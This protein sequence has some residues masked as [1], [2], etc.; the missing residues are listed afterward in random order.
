MTVTLTAAESFTPE[1]YF[2]AARGLASQ[3]RIANDV[4]DG[5]NSIQSL[6][7]EDWRGEAATAFAVRT[8]SVSGSV[9]ELAISLDRHADLL[10]WYASAK[11]AVCER[12]VAAA[13]R[14]KAAGFEVSDDWRLSLSDKQKRGTGRGFLI[15]QMAS[16]QIALNAFAHAITLVDVQATAQL[17]NGGAA[18][19]MSPHDAAYATSN[20]YTTGDSPDRTIN[21]DDDF[22]FGSKRGEATPEDLKLWLKWEAMLR[23]AQMLRPDLDDALPMYEHFRDAS[24]T[25]MTFD[26]E[27]AYREDASI[28]KEID[29]EM[30]EVVAAANEL[31]Q[32]GY[33]DTDFHSEIKTSTFYPETENWQKAVGGYS[34]YSDT[35][36]KVEGDTITVT[37]T[38]TAKDRWNFNDG[39][40]DIATGTPDSENGRFEELGW[41]QSFDTSGTVTRTVSWRVG[42]EPPQFGDDATQDVGG[43]RNDESRDRNDWRSGWDNGG[44]R[45]P[46]NEPGGDDKVNRYPDGRQY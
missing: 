25:P 38:I 7:A 14:M 1:P 31:A 9:K 40:G 19:P 12:A 24:G 16:M 28:R 23:G 22:P 13:R 21:F 43:W 18:A 46:R 11:T 15:I 10:T 17:T 36:M 37:T 20:G 27:E 39:A 45:Y 34:Y 3:R 44:G 32:N 5:I 30:N 26:F 42:E 6:A 35:T 4:A 41:A 33:T 29:S 8:D 2:R